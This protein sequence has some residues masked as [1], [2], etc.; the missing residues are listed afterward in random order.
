MDDGIIP[1]LNARLEEMGEAAG[2]ASKSL[3][4]ACRALDEI[5]ALCDTQVPDDADDDAL[6]R[7]RRAAAQADVSLEAVASEIQRIGAAIDAVAGL[8]DD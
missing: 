7:A 5:E 1:A 3:R 6:N 2:G 8:D 4:A